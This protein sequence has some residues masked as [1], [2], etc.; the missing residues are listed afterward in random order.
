MNFRCAS[1]NTW[2]AWMNHSPNLLRMSVLAHPLR[3]KRC[4]PGYL[5]VRI[6]CCTTRV[7]SAIQPKNI[8]RCSPVSFGSSPPGFPSLPGKKR[9]RSLRPAFNLL[10]VI[11][12]LPPMSLDQNPAIMA[13]YPVMSNPYRMRMWGTVPAAG[14]PDIMCAIPTVVAGDPDEA[15]IRWRAWTLH[16]R[17]RRPYMHIDLRK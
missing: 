3:R 4:T 17:S 10:S 15:S 1:I 16:N 12:N 13:V 7:A 5:E 2:L 6:R 8:Y 11:F 14:N 9:K